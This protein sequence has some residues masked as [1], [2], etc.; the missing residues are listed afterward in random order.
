MHLFPAAARACSILAILSILTIA[1][2]EAQDQSPVKD[3][4]RYVRMAA[5]TKYIRSAGYQKRWGSHYRAEWQT[6]VLFHKAMLDTLAGG[7]YPYQTGGGR[8]SK[9]LR[10]HD[11][12]EHEY[13]LR[14]IDKTFGKALPEIAQDTWVED[15]A[16]DQVTIAHP[17]A[18]LIVAPLAAAAGIYHTE[19]H[20][21]YIPKQP[22]LGKFNDS[23]GNI[24][25]MFEQRPDEN[26]STAPNFGNSKKIVST[27]KMLENIL[28][29]NDRF[30]DQRAFL[31]ARLFD[32]W[33]GDWGRHDDQ[34]RWASFK[35]D[36]KTTYVPIPRDRD[37][38][39][40]KFDGRFVKIALG[41]AGADHL[42]TFDNTLKDVNRFNFP[43][44]H[45]DHH[46]LNQL[47]ME[48]WMDVAKELQESLTDNVIDRAVH[49]MPPEVYPISGPEIASKLR[50]RRGELQNY[51]HEYFLFL[52]KEVEITGTEDQEKFVVTRNSDQATTV[53][54]YK[55]TN[56]G[57][58]KDKPF[59]ER[60]FNNY[61][62]KE[63]RLYGIK[64]EDQFETSGSAGTTPL[65]RFIGG[66][67]K[68]VYTINSTGPAGKT[69]IYDDRGD[70]S[71]Q[72][73]GNS[74]KK[75]RNDS[76]IHAYNYKYFEYDKSGL[77][78]IVFY[79]NEDRIYAG[80]AYS[81]TKQKWRKEPFGIK[82]YIDVKY[83]ITQ[84]AISSTYKSTF[85]QAIGKWDINTLAN[86]DAIR[87]TNFYGLG[88]ETV[89]TT[90]DRDYNRMRSKIFIGSIGLD[91]VVNG[92]SHFGI[93]PFYQSIDI[94]T[95]TARFLVKQTPYN[96][97]LTFDKHQFAGAEIFYLF[98]KL[99][100]SILPMKGVSFLLKGSQTSGLGS[101]NNSVQ[102]YGGELNLLAKLTKHIGI[103][104][105]GGGASLSGDPLF[106]QYNTIG[107]TR[108]LRG[109]QRDRFYGKSTFYNQNELRWVSDVRSHLF[110][111][112]I[113][114]YGLYDIGRVWLDKQD[115]NTW[116]DS[117]GAGFMLSPFNKITLNFAYAIS[118]E[119]S[120]IH[121]GI[122]KPL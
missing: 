34:W 115:S 88:N 86:Y 89:L 96:T 74:R 28:E 99:N 56:E 64:G 58:V 54:I 13:V 47:S 76:S 53:S 101:L 103:S 102:K 72:G 69:R 116:H 117:Y 85:K 41:F 91:R 80:L 44:R 77:K 90:K 61:E 48:D 62:T 120:N 20:A 36:K 2:V 121:F 5:S 81:S 75:L 93:T 67:D 25:Y 10:L 27:E 24:L 106:Y 113:A 8:Q 21:Y 111:G 38:A 112:K 108:T 60:V 3:S 82:H 63:I 55:I 94:L 114:L 19:P 30:V 43:S 9:S 49:A 119:D 23:T 97:A 95:D 14:S 18:A 46:L 110:N 39:F 51:A 26:W 33:I 71:F 122:V 109:Y 70:N 59:Y 31:K 6:P 32:M 16:N 107:G 92:T 98:Q 84:K 50:S 118:P 100:D 57:K 65:I 68:D 15:L 52:N 37:N 42:Q 66:K 83:S 79:N 22:A 1:T 105:K 104:V 11:K 17:Y 40:T 7:V 29:D 45:L 12:A 4:G 87:W 73:S 78:P 35:D